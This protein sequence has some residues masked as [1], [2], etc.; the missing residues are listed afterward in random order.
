[1]SICYLNHT[2]NF[3]VIPTYRVDLILSHEFQF[4]TRTKRLHWDT[5]TVHH[6]WSCNV[7]TTLH[8]WKLGFAIFIGKCFV[9]SWTLYY[10][11]SC[12]CTF[13]NFTLSINGPFLRYLSP[14]P[15]VGGRTLRPTA[16]KT[17]EMN[18]LEVIKTLY[19]SERITLRDKKVTAF[20]KILSLA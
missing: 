14:G 20:W 7:I 16:P 17:S 9:D 13:T 15:F 6:W 1:M 8:E 18:V 19:K 11:Q 5:F 12:T 4:R 10:W 2:V 3:T